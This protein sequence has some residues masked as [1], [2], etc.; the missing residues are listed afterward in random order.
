MKGSRESYLTS[1]KGTHG[2]AVKGTHQSDDFRFAHVFYGEFKLRIQLIR[3][4]CWTETPCLSLSALGTSFL[5]N[6]A[7]LDRCSR[8]R[9]K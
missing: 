2:F 6:S 4:R 7:R 1:R 9:D 5:T 8:L 3:R